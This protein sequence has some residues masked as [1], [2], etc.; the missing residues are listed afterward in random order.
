MTLASITWDGPDHPTVLLAHATGF[1]KLVWRPFVRALRDAGVEQRIV[2]HDFRSHGHS[3]KLADH[4]WQFYADDVS[5]ILETI[6][7]PVVGIGH[8]MGGAALIEAG[9]AHPDR[10]MGMVLVEPIVFPAAMLPDG[11]DSPMA[12]GARRRRR[13]FDSPGH[14]L[15]NFAAKP[16]FG[17]WVPDALAAYVEGGLIAEGDDHVLACEPSDEAATF[18]EAT[19]MRLFERLDAVTV[20]AIIVWGTES[21]AYP[22]GHAEELGHRMP[23]SS[24][25]TMKGAGHFIP[26][27]SPQLLAEIVAAA[28]RS[29]FAQLPNQT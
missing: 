1:H 26:M 21:D 15:A 6:E 10:F 2:A 22:A 20:P 9:I 11:V 14:A 17:R 12:A 16:V 5:D 24:V 18:G 8:S 4:H 28:L 27:E 29:G 19:S 7:G 13:A 25:V 3:P 23:N